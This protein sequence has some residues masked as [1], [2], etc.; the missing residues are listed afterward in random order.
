MLRLWVWGEL[1]REHLLEH[2]VIDLSKADMPYTCPHGR[3]TLIYTS[4]REINR[5][6][7][8]E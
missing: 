7:G 1:S 8:R 5:K 4:F 3:P 6:F 2:L